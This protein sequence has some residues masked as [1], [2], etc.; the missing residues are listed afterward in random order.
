MAKDGRSTKKAKRQTA[1]TFDQNEEPTV[2]EPAT[3]KGLIE[4]LMRHLEATLKCL[5]DSQGYMTEALQRENCR[6]AE[7]LY[8]TENENLKSENLYLRELLQGILGKM[9]LDKTEAK[10]M[11]DLMICS[12]SGK[13]ETLL[14]RLRD[15]KASSLSAPT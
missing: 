3:N 9:S 11:I 1:H 15:A 13:L 6:L 8:N 7:L 10:S 4:Q 14:N 5:C 2:P 12:A